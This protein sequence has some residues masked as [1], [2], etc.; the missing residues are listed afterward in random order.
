MKKLL[1]GAV[2][3]LSANAYAEDAHAATLKEVMQQLGQS[4]AT[5][6]HAI[7]IGDF[8]QAIVSAKAISDHEKPSMG[9]RMKIMATLGTDMVDFK[10]TDQKVHQL[11]LDIEQAATAKDMPLLIKRQSQMLSACMACH[12]TYRS[13]VMEAMK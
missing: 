13:T 5:L 7:L 12:T 8:D 10:N 11:A 2:I 4:Y 1:L 9:Q 3:A 6:N